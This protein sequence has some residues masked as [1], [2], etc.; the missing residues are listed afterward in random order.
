VTIPLDVS[1]PISTPKK[2]LIVL[3]LVILNLLPMS[4]MACI[5]WCSLGPVTILSSVYVV[6]ITPHRQTLAKTYLFETLC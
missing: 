4:F 2:S 1:R 6:R 3:Q 5:I